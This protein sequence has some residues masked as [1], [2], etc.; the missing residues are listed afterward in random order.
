MW[1]YYTSKKWKR[2]C[3]NTE[4]DGNVAF[5]CQFC[6]RAFQLLSTMLFCAKTNQRAFLFILHDVHTHTGFGVYFNYYKGI[7]LRLYMKLLIWVSSDQVVTWI[8]PLDTLQ[9][10]I[11]ATPLFTYISLH[12]QV[13]NL[14]TK[15]Q[16]VPSIH[17]I[18]TWNNIDI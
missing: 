13:D 8:M 3:T 9:S 18:Q 11:D 12:P 2:G 5:H 15:L 6:F 16:L 1:K 7:Q 14:H 10:W 4:T 17:K